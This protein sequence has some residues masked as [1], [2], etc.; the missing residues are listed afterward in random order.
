[1]GPHPSEQHFTRGD[2]SK[3]ATKDG[4]RVSFQEKHISGQNKSFK[5]QRN[6]RMQKLSFSLH[7]SK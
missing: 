7:F 2:A 5:T 1:L 4:A 6:I 3:E